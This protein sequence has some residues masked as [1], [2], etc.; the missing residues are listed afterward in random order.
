MKFQSLLNNSY[1]HGSSPVPPWYFPAA[2][3]LSGKSFPNSPSSAKKQ[4][5]V[6]LILPSASATVV[7]QVVAAALTVALTSA[8][9]S[10]GKSIR[11]KMRAEKL[12]TPVPGPKGRFLLGFVPE[13]S[14]NLQRIYDFQVRNVL[15]NQR[16]F[17]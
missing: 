9:V 8:L 4:A 14:K 13:L 11:R 17:T 1:L 16:T 12:L 7:A 3:M 6:M 5:A 10:I 15:Y 2:R